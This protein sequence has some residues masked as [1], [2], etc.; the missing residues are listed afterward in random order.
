MRFLQ[1]KGAF[2]ID[3][4]IR[5]A[6]ATSAVVRRV[7]MRTFSL[8]VADEARRISANVRKSAEMPRHSA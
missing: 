1:V 3:N 6:S 7:S 5:G 8:P 2:H 4:A